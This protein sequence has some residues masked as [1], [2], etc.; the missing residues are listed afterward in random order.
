MAAVQ[1]ERSPYFR[2]ALNV[3]IGMMA[4]SLLWS[5]LSSG[6]TGEAHYRS[7]GNL[8]TKYAW[9]ARGIFPAKA[10]Y[11][12]VLSDY[13]LD[14]EYLRDLKLWRVRFRNEKQFEFSA[15]DESLL[16]IDTEYGVRRLDVRPTKNLFDKIEAR[17]AEAESHR[18]TSAEQ[19]LE[20]VNKS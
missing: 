18:F 2:T 12:F 19:F 6:G 13:P 4:I 5:L 10:E 7:F 3:I 17:R 8:E 16:W 14:L 9:R 1:T 20:F 11:L 15:G